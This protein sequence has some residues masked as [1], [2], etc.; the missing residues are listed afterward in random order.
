MDLKIPA[1]KLYMASGGEWGQLLEM[2]SS[3]WRFTF[4]DWTDFAAD[5]GKPLFALR[6]QIPWIHSLD[7]VVNTNLWA[8][9]SREWDYWVIE[10]NTIDD[11]QR[12]RS[13]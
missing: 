10:K 3:L 11:Q 13:W 7:K 12:Y 9:V 6:V 1:S 5:P 4:S 8:K 2:R